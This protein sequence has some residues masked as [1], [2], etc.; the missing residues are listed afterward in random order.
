[1]NNYNVETAQYTI[2]RHKA[3]ALFTTNTCLT[4]KTYSLSYIKNKTGNANI[5]LSTWYKEVQKKYLKTSRK[6]FHP[7]Q[8]SG[9]KTYTQTVS[10]IHCKETYTMKKL[11]FYF[12]HSAIWCEQVKT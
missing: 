6:K 3:Q 9:L 10:S 12:M 11:K 4:N 5:Y 7:L 2:T 1:V 8:V